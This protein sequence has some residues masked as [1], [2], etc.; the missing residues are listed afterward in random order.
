MMEHN[1]PQ[2]KQLTFARQVR[3]SAPLPR[4][5][6]PPWERVAQPVEQ[7]TFNQ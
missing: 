5:T 4:Q 6:L 7:L 3:M 2:A 1:L